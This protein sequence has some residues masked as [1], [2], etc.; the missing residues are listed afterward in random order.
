M[1]KVNYRSDF[2]EAYNYDSSI[3]YSKEV[4]K[5]NKATEEGNKQTQRELIDRHGG[6]ISLFAKRQYQTDR[7]EELHTYTDE[8]LATELRQRGFE[9]WKWD[10]LPDWKENL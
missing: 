2:R 3:D 5:W 10:R 7:R 1:S 4:E 8:E 6:I 9:V